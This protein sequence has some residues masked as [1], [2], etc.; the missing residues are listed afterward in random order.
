[1]SMAA[2]GG[3]RRP[4]KRE[5]IPVELTAEQFYELERLW[6]YYGNRGPKTT[7]G[8]HGFIQ[9]LIERFQDERPKRSKYSTPTPDCEGAVENILAGR[10]STEGLDE[11]Q[12]AI[13]DYRIKQWERRVEAEKEW[14]SQL[15]HRRIT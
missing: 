15:K 2:A 7:P 10:I 12:K 3:R 6:Y 14:L 4:Q 5:P 9:G 1:M 8:N 11:R 13:R